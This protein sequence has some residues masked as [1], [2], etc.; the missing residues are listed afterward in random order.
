MCD[1]S[2]QGIVAAMSHVRDLVGASYIALGSDFD[3]SVATRFDTSQLAVITQALLDANFS[4]R[5]IA[6]IMGGNALRLF[7][8]LLPRS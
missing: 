2:P 6:A 5:E 7:Y 8:Q 4:E 1:T 3:G